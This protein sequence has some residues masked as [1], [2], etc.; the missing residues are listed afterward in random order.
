MEHSSIT[1]SFILMTQ[2]E[3]NAMQVVL[4]VHP[5]VHDV[6]IT[7]RTNM[8]GE[9]RIVAYVVPADVRTA[10]V[11]RTDLEQSLP[12]HVSID[13]YVLLTA[14]PRTSNGGV[15][16]A[17]LAQVEVIDAL[18]L[19]RWRRSL[20]E[21]E[22]INAFEVMVVERNLGAAPF[23]RMDLLPPLL[24]PLNLTEKTGEF[25]SNIVA[26]ETTAKTAPRPAL[27]HGAELVLDETHPATLGDALRR[28]AENYPAHGVTYV[29]SNGEQ[30]FQSY[31]DLLAEAECFLK[32]LR[33]AG[34]KQGD[35]VLLQVRENRDFLVAFWAS[36]L[37]GI[38]P[39]PVSIA[40]IYM[41]SSAVVKKLL[42]VWL[43]LDKPPVLASSDIKV[44]LQLVFDQSGAV[45]ARVIAMS[46]LVEEDGASE[47]NIASD[48][49]VLLLL[50]SGSTGL[51]KAVMHSH[52]TLLN[53]SASSIAYNGF[54]SDDISLNWMPLDHVG[55]IVMFHLRDVYAGCQQIQVA[56]SWI[57]E[58]PLRWLALIDQYRASITWAPN[59]A[60]ALVNEKADE[61]AGQSWDLSCMRHSL[62]GGE[63]VVAKTARQYL[64]LTAPYGMSPTSMKPA[65]GMS[66]T[67]SGVTDSHDF[68]LASTS[69]DDRTVEVGKPI[70]N[71]SI[72]IV[73]E[74]HQLLAE[75]EKGRLQVKG[76]CVM[77]GYFH[78]PEANSQ[79]FTEDGWLDTGDVGYL[80]NDRLTVTART[81]DEIIING[82]NYLAAEIEVV[83]EAVGGVEVSYTA[84]CAVRAGDSDTDELAIFVHPNVASDRELARTLRLVREQVTSS[85]GVRPTYVVPVEKHQ[86]PKTN[87][88][89]IQRTKLKQGL[90]NGEFDTELKRSDLLT[91]THTIP[92]WFYHKVW[93]SKA[94]AAQ[95][96]L[97]DLGT[98]L[99][100]VDD[101]GLANAVCERLNQSGQCYITV[102][103]GEVF[104]RLRDNQYCLNPESADDYQQLIADIQLSQQR[105]GQVLHFWTY[106]D[107]AQEIENIDNFWQSQY[108]G[109]FS[110]LYLVR[111]LVKNSEDEAPIALHVFSS[112]TQMTSENDRSTCEHATVI[113]MLKTIPLE[114]AWIK[115]RHIDLQSVD[116]ETNCEH[117]VNEIQIAD[118]EDEVAY[119]NQQR[120]VWGLSRVDMVQSAPVE[121]PI[122]Q[123]GIY[124]ITGGLGGIGSALAKYLSTN[125]S[126]RLILI[127]TTT[128]PESYDWSEYLAQD[129][130]QG[131][132]LRVYREIESMGVE[133]IYQAVDVADPL[134]LEEV[135][136][137]A[138]KQWGG[139]MAG[140]FHLASGGDPALHWKDMDRYR[141]AV[142]SS[143]VYDWMFRSKVYGAIAIHKLLKARP[144][145]IN[146]SFSS[147]ISLFGG[148]TFSA[149]AA[150]QSF[151]NC[152]SNRNRGDGHPNTYNFIWS[153]WDSIGMSKGDPDFVRQVYLNAGYSMITQEIGLDCLA[154]AL[155]RNQPELVI[156]LDSSKANVFHHLL[157][158]PQPLNG[159]AAFYTSD[160][161]LSAM[162]DKLLAM[163]VEDGF[164]TRS[165][166]DFL[167]IE[168]MPMDNNHKVDH[169]ALLAYKADEE[170][171][172][173]IVLPRTETENR[174]AGIWAD[175]LATSMNNMD[176]NASFFQLG[177][178]SLVATQVLSRLNQSFNVKLNMRDLFE[179]STIAL[180]A[181]CLQQAQGDAPIESHD[182][183]P[184][185]QDYESLLT[186]VD[187][188]SDEEVEQLLKEMQNQ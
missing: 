33:G 22:G 99:V 129:N 148:A 132:R 6:V 77:L 184:E 126:A 37:G 65:W 146:V 93:L 98:S 62:N 18:L 156:G 14:L 29:A 63:A 78:N 15:D 54:R 46:E 69:D 154:S 72:R 104:A 39:V 150:A 151:L 20:V 24:K 182:E 28:A 87:I 108:Q 172:Q 41:S 7:S 163:L 1:E 50:T 75:G 92:D 121:M 159:V 143:D 40:P 135:V 160:Q 112:N 26:D 179:Y 67:S 162:Q 136:A 102:S 59:F 10:A 70:H 43:M 133:F 8:S 183:E 158:E 89:K 4:A 79:T 57:L 12:A 23:H 16:I 71:M 157:D 13:E 52:Q 32:C 105:I 117:V 49:L 139:E 145:A 106:T 45:E 90:E 186:D 167:E 119:R 97:T 181:G 177:G 100:F 19:D 140:V 171:G 103:A 47:V 141:V 187:G 74:H 107:N 165:R 176:V 131:E 152:Y 128:L 38:V 188:M 178:N 113:G 82:V 115:C 9:E 83:A 127:G 134:A 169:E 144:K 34:I 21:V 111:A 66:E 27:V 95:T 109:L 120:L 101:L 170:S 61:F 58:E 17:C 80:V 85:V 81:K 124:L 164:G 155:Y 175:V 60:Y 149:Y 5:T 122:K 51:P 138:E 142:Q 125:Y 84:A 94:V 11:I 31:P 180:L 30:S 73:D 147:V 2:H 88:G 123:G 44:D 185:L 35:K 48:D 137:A 116:I 173:E 68:S 166:C 130:K 76:P 118:G 114:T 168:S 55:G 96:A 3:I 174:V 42:N 86:I 161:A 25:Y 91:E 36:M 64:R 153:V 110:L 53:R 56:T